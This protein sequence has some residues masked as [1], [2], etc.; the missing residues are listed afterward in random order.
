MLNVNRDVVYQP[1]DSYLFVVAATPT[2]LVTA[3]QLT[4]QDLITSFIISV[5]AAAAGNIFLGGPGVTIANGIEIVAGA[6]PV[7]FVIENQNQHYELQEPVLRLAETMQCQPNPPVSLPIVV[8]DF[9][10][11]YAVAAANTNARIAPFRSMFI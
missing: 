4:K 2:P 11:I 1:F 7:R 3:V 6:G 9:N 5:D 10:Q 8:W